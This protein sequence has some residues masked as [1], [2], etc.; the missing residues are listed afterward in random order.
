MFLKRAERTQ[1]YKKKL[2]LELLTKKKPAIS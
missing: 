2:Q 1:N